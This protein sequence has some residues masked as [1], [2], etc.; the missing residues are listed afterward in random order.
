MTPFFSKK[1]Y[2]SVRDVSKSSTFF[3]K[4]EKMKCRPHLY[5]P[6]VRLCV[7]NEVFYSKLLIFYR[8]KKFQNLG[9]SG[10]KMTK[11]CPIFPEK[12]TSKFSWN[13]LWNTVEI[14]VNEKT[15]GNKKGAIFGPNFGQFSKNPENCPRRG[16]RLI[17]WNS[18]PKTLSC[19]FLDLVFTPP[20][21]TP[22]WPE[23]PPEF[24]GVFPRNFPEILLFQKAEMP[25]FLVPYG[26]KLGW[27]FRGGGRGVLRFRQILAH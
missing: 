12:M 27:F 20:K 16:A 7:K 10:A 5:F 15:R 4:I 24:P 13:T 8:S 19:S 25:W 18:F 14:D 1:S 22:F 21:S 2:F 3:Q 9:G 26:V 17:D 6:L 11:F 23:N